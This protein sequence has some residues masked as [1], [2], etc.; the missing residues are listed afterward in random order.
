M[1]RRHTHTVKYILLSETKMI[2]N[3]I[4]FSLVAMRF[5]ATTSN[6]NQPLKNY[7]TSKNPYL[8]AMI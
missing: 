2:S 8:Y 5:L 7:N 1:N 4:A 3:R 6:R